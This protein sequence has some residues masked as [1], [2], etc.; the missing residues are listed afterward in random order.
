MAGCVVP[1]TYASNTAGADALESWRLHEGVGGLRSGMIDLNGDGVDEYVVLATDQG[2]C[3][4]GGC[5]VFVLSADAGVLRT[6]SRSTIT[7]GPI[8]ALTTTTRGWRDLV[9]RVGGGGVETHD[10]VLRWTGN[11]YPAN[12]SLAPL[13]SGRSAGE[14]V[15]LPD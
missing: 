6:V 14:T 3:G 10:V 4:S 8:R 13:S 5:T 9:V 2:Y 1:D 11:G 12:P 7:R 15:V